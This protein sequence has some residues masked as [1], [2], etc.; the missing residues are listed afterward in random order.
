MDPDEVVALTPAEQSDVV[1]RGVVA[2][3]ERLRG[4]LEDVLARLTEADVA[5]PSRLPG[6]TRGNVLAHLAGVGSSAARQLEHARA[7][8]LVD[9]YDGGRPGRDAAIEA[10]AGAPA[11]VHVRDV[12]AAALRVESALAALG[13][14]DWDAPTR[15]RDQPATAVAHAW[16]RELGIHLVD[17]DV[18]VGQDVWSPALLDHLVEFLAPRVPAGQLVALAPGGGASRWELGDGGL[19]RVHGERAEDLVAWLA[20]REP[21]GPVTAE[22]DGE[23]VSLP[24]LGPWP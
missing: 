16:W 13:P 2:D 23:P 17:L 4:V 8:R 9:F 1:G 6:W 7:R 24:E 12:L 10:G 15:Y 18:G 22:R 21:S 5:A 20:G 19:V 3:V 11:E 14:E